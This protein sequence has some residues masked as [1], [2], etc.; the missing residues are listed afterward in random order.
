MGE[1]CSPP[2]NHSPP[3]SLPPRHRNLPQPQNGILYCGAAALLIRKGTDKDKQWNFSAMAALAAQLWAARRRSRSARIPAGRL[4]VYVPVCRAAGVWRS[5]LPPKE[6]KNRY[7]AHWQRPQCDLLGRW[8]QPLPYLRVRQPSWHFVFLL[9]VAHFDVI[10]ED[11]VVASFSQAEIS[12]QL[13]L[14]LLYLQQIILTG[15]GLSGAIL[16]QLGTKHRT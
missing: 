10:T 7:H 4:A 3:A 6:D 16:V 15:V 14:A 12:C 13:T 1:Q 2:T 11:I 8:H 9:R 5:L